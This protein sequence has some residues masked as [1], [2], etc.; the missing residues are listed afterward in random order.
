MERNLTRAALDAVFGAH[1]DLAPLA[2]KLADGV[3]SNVLINLL[4]ALG[5][6]SKPA[7]LADAPKVLA[8]SFDN[9]TKGVLSKLALVINTFLCEEIAAA[10][11]T[12]KQV[13]Q[14]RSEEKQ[15]KLQAAIAAERAAA[16]PPG[17]VMSVFNAHEAAAEVDAY[18]NLAKKRNHFETEGLL[19]KVTIPSA[20]VRLQ[21]VQYQHYVDNK[22]ELL[23]EIGFTLVSS[24]KVPGD[25]RED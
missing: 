2:G 23:E 9:A 14:E 12:K 25:R 8:S 6:P 21:Q 7:A 20:D 3:D 1:T 15:R 24:E 11:V 18:A 17:A 10:K 4:E 22:S 19:F 13:K 5:L 16:V